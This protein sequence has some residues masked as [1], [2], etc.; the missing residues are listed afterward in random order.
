MEAVKKFWL[1]RKLYVWAWAIIDYAGKQAAG[2]ILIYDNGWL[3]IN[4]RQ[5]YRHI[6]IKWQGRELYR[7]DRTSVYVN[8]YNATCARDVEKRGKECLEML[9][10]I[11]KSKEV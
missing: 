8:K 2:N 4:A 10:I 6:Q 7:A 9:E 3:V 1:R 11:R 5:E